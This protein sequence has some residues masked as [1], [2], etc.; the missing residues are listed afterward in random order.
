[1]RREGKTFLLVAPSGW[2]RASCLRIGAIAAEALMSN[3]G[4]TML[5]VV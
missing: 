5:E 3:A 4:K 2:P 1:M